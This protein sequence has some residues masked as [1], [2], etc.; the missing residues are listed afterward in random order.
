MANPLRM[1][2]RRNGAHEVSRDPPGTSENA[3]KDAKAQNF[4]SPILSALV[5]SCEI[6]F[7]DRPGKTERSGPHV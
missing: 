6:K 5:S 1:V 4:R 7:P 3:R 2:P